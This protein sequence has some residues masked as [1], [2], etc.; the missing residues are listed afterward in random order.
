M[1]K[2][3]TA[4]A[5]AAAAVA[6]AVLPAVAAAAPSG[7]DVTV[8]SRVV[9][10]VSGSAIGVNTPF[11]NGDLT[12]SQTPA[13]IRGAGLRTLE[14]NAGGPS[15]LYHFENGGWLS[16]DPLGEQNGGYQDQV[17]Q[18]S[19]DQFA[20]TAIASHA[21]MLVHVN[22]GTGPTDTAAHPS[23]PA[24]PK[25]GDPAEAAAW[26]RYANVVHHY[27]V[28][29]WV[30]GEEVWFNG[31]VSLP[32]FNL[33][34]EPDAHTDK[35]PSAYAR[36]TLDYVKAMKAV[37][38][39]I[40]IGIEL[41]PY[42]PANLAAGGLD[43]G[44][45][46]WDDTVLSAPGLADSIDFVDVH[47]YNA[48]VGGVSSDAGVLADTSHVAP[49]MAS[50]R[51]ELDSVSGRRQH[52]SIVAGETNSA[53]IARQQ[54]DGPVGALFLLD[55]NL[56]LLDNGVS[57]IDWWGLYD[58]PRAGTDGSWG[59]LGLLSSGTCPA[60]T[61]S[62]QSCE[63]A[64]GTPFAPYYTMRM[65]TSALG[66]GGSLLATTSGSSTLGAHAIRRSDGTLAVVLVNKDPQQA[67]NVHLTVP[68][69]YRA[70]RTL[71]WRQGMTDAATTWGPAPATLAP[72]S[73]T[74]T[75]YAP[76]HRR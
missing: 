36:N 48:A 39:R 27:D 43:A 60:G 6:A 68:A 64:V 12:R 44:M 22:Y 9:N 53:T 11:Y 26:V 45:K 63:P 51:A 19:F 62:G 4:L 67:Q 23:T 35:S 59:D 14:F 50:L 46:A 10:T 29:D 55:D 58:I 52:I 69:G 31:S 17:P 34:L 54:Q 1:S 7:T 8:G 49:A 41:Y 2:R 13:L 70:T 76:A 71:T 66:G 72:Y 40:K 42:D 37:D 57:S 33:P 5:V 20:H 75:F 73:A 16:P 25:P 28:R 24:D 56:A 65:L 47:W 18:Y 30:I 61:P 3:F 74:V 15:D 32:G 21:G 38:P